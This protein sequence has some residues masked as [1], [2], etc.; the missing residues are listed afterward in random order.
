LRKEREKPTSKRS[1]V[2]KRRRMQKF[3]VLDG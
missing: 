3:K 2:V 1:M